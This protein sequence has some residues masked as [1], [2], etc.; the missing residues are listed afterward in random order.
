[1]NR[2][3]LKYLEV[4]SCN[5]KHPCTLRCLETLSCHHH[6]EFRKK[7]SDELKKMVFSS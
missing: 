6:P 4:A 7:M 3:G 2:F 5:P 1:M